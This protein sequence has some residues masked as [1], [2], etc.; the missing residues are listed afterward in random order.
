MTPA[1]TGKAQGSA[2]L[3][4]VPLALVPWKRCSSSLATEVISRLVTSDASLLARMKRRALIPLRPPRPPRYVGLTAR[5]GRGSSRPSGIKPAG[6]CC[7]FWRPV[8]SE[9]I[10]PA[11]NFGQARASAARMTRDNYS[12]LAAHFGKRGQF[13]RVAQIRVGVSLDR[14]KIRRVNIWFASILY[15]AR[16]GPL[17]YFYLEMHTHSL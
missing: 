10:F 6:R 11:A 17:T 7:R 1:C 9:L 3:A 16:L 2:G 4:I 14:V 12:V 15:G 8:L 13:W 5:G